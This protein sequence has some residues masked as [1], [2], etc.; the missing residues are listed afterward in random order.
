MWRTRLRLCEVSGAIMHVCR[1][2]P[3]P[4]EYGDCTRK[5]LEEARAQ[6]ERREAERGLEGHAGGR[7]A[8]GE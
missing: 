5:A 1:V 7:Q 8:E 2:G 6:K 3:P 4:V